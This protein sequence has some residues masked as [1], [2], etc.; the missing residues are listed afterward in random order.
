MKQAFGLLTNKR[1][2]NKALFLIL[3]FVFMLSGCGKDDDNDTEQSADWNINATIYMGGEFAV[4]ATAEI[5]ISGETFTANV[6]T[7]TIAGQA[8]AH[9][10]SI[11]G[12][13]NGNTLTISN[14]SFSINVGG[15]TNTVVMSGTVTINNDALT[16]NGTIS[17]NI[18]DVG[19]VDG[20]FT[21]TGSN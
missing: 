12:T 5:T 18:P 6:T 8:E 3:S 16:G 17:E 19:T 15:S 11:S 4:V 20:T 10:V 1:I 13:A 21:V 7:V 2:M 14:E 9:N